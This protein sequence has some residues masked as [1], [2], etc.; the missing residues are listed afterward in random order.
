[1]VS[2]GPSD[3]AM[4][5]QFAKQ[6]SMQPKAIALAA[7]MVLL[8]GLV[9][10]LPFVPFVLL[11]VTM[12]GIAYALH[13]RQKETQARE[14]AEQAALQPA[15]PPPGPEQVEALLPL[16]ALELEVGYGAHTPGG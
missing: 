11:G 2:R 16:D 1:M 14:A 5:Q 8:F 6:F 10:G 13:K 12:G 7:A 9:P 3:T 15:P 4:G